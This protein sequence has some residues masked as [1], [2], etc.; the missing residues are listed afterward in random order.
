[1]RS[2]LKRYKFYKILN[3]SSLVPI[4]KSN[5]VQFA[6]IPTR[7]PSVLLLCVEV[8]ASHFSKG[9]LFQGLLSAGIFA[10]PLLSLLGA[11]RRGR[12]KNRWIS[13]FNAVGDVMFSHGEC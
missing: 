6:V 3:I 7:S 13:C 1:M 8:K 12:E 5:Q 10:W 9:E 4:T 11:S 2:I